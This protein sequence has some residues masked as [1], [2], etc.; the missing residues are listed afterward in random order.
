MSAL[1]SNASSHRPSRSTWR[2]A[3]IGTPLGWAISLALATLGTYLLVTHTN[4]VAAALPYILLMACPLLHLVLHG[5]HGHH[6]R[7][8][9]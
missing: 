1:S 4:H 3:L 9:K 7:E 6:G 8:H 5:G 2:A